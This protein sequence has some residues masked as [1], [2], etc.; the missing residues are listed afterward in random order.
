MNSVYGKL[1]GVTECH[2]FNGRSLVL[3][4]PNDSKE[5]V[6]KWA[7]EMLR[8]IAN[9]YD[10][11]VDALTV[12]YENNCY[13]MKLHSGE[14]FECVYRLYGGPNDIK[15]S[16]LSDAI[17][18]LAMQNLKYVQDTDYK[19]EC[20]YV[21]DKQLH[22]F[23]EYLKKRAP[24]FHDKPLFESYDPDWFHGTVKKLRQAREMFNI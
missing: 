21:A 4:T 12:S 3:K 7:W 11:R 5:Y 24:R 10:V 1:D 16:Q 22:E 14:P 13:I 20:I 15:L 23:G 9:V 19:D 8:H 17:H 18:K 2:P 6:G